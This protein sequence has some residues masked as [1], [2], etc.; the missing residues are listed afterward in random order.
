MRNDKISR[1]EFLAGFVTAVSAC[2]LGPA[3]T[4][5][6]LTALAN[7]AQG[8]KPELPLAPTK[9]PQRILGRTGVKVSILGMGGAEYFQRA[10]NQEAVDLL[11]NKAIDSGI[12]YFDTCRSYGNSEAN[13]SG[14]LSKRRKEI[15]LATKC[16]HRDYDG[17]MKEV[18][19]SLT[20]LKMDH[21][22]LMQVH[23]VYDKDDLAKIFQKDGVVAALEKLRDQKV[24]RFIGVT[25]HPEYANVAKVLDMYD[26]DTFLG[27]INPMASTRPMYDDQLPICIRKK[28]G[29]AAMKIFGGSTPGQMVGDT[30]GKASAKQLL[31][32]ALSQN[33]TVVVPP[34][35]NMTQLEENLAV[36]KNFTPMTSDEREAIIAQVNQTPLH[37]ARPMSEIYP[38]QHITA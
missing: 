31:R 6:A 24:I 10:R 26:W 15:F 1:R 32:Y 28:M 18:E 3:L 13:I 22:D 2:A 4:S 34:V 16:D 9:L 17:V 35:A 5:T 8:A 12:N 11:L 19:L 14:V 36:A 20:T 38:F 21:I 23:H 37:A 7:P 30:P 29:V 33:I 25:G 27:F